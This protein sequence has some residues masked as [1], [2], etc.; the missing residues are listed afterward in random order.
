MIKDLK[1]MKINSANFLYFIINKVN[2]YFEEINKTK[3]L[4]LV[5][6]NE[7]KKELWSKIRD[8]IRLIGPK[9]CFQK[10]AG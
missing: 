8:L 4:M 2:G 5:P 1:Y 6:N 10:S 7:S 9:T 3:Y